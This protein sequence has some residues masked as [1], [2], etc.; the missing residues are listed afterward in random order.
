MFSSE[1]EVLSHRSRE[2]PSSNN[3]KIRDSLEKNKKYISKILMMTDRE[4]ILKLLQNCEKVHSL[5]LQGQDAF[6]MWYLLKD[7]LL[8]HFQRASLAKLGVW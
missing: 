2:R 8:F 7:V 1:K 3:T 5:F 4:N 6:N